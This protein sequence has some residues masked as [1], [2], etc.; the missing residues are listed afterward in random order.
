MARSV[1]NSSLV[2][3]GA[4]PYNGNETTP[5]VSTVTAVSPGTFPN[6]FTND[7]NDADFGVTTDMYLDQWTPTGTSASQSLNVTATAAAA[8]VPE[9]FTVSFAS[10]SGMGLNVSQDGKSLVFM[11]YNSPINQLDVSNSNT[12]DVVDPTNPDFQTATY[13]T[14][15][16]LNFSTGALSFTH[17]DAYSGDDARSATLANGMFYMVG[18]A[19]NSG[20]SPNPTYGEYDILSM[21]TGLQ[22]IAPGSTCAYT[23]VIGTFYS[24][25]SSTYAPA[26]TGTCA[27][28]VITDALSATTYAKKTSM[29]GNQFGFSLANLTGQTF[30]KSSK[31]DNFRGMFVD[32]KGTMYVSKDSGSNGVDTVYQVGST[33]ALANGATLAQNTAISIVPGFPT[34]TMTAGDTETSFPN[35]W[36]LATGVGFPSSMWVP[37]N[38][39]NLMFV[40]DEGDYGDSGTVAYAPN[41]SGGLWVYLNQAG[42]WSPIAH[43]TAGLNLGVAYTVTDAVG[44]YGT[45]GAI[46]TTT[47]EGLR[48]VT[49]RINSDGS[50]TL[51]ATTSTIGNSTSTAF[52]AGA[53]SNQLVKITVN[54]SGSTVTTNGFSVMETA[55]FGQ[56]LRGVAVVPSGS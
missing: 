23:Q 53:D 24:G 51:Y 30:D 27:M 43:L 22:S 41:G 10:Q 55:P 2:V 48:H 14:V 42:T 52:D 35:P 3:N 9:N 44:T 34:S 56:V 31:D 19:G 40:A 49:G 13:R 32:A 15:A 12:P 46:Y 50:Y 11:G 36:T 33:G 20:S 5:A 45:V 26:A 38:N 7:A 1:Y 29:G 47:P 18:A 54:V 21:D 16:Q 17:T 25:N 37:S 28:G 8:S 39:T 6:V 4:L